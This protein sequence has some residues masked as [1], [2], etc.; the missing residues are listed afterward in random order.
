[1]TDRSSAIQD[2]KDTILSDGFSSDGFSKD[3]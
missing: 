3:A 1:M 2:L